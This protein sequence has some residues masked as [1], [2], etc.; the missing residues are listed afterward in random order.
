MSILRGI[1]YPWFRNNRTISGTETGKASTEIAPHKGTA[2]REE[3]FDKGLQT[4]KDLESH[5]QAFFT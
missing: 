4:E 3:E 2:T 5:I 1:I